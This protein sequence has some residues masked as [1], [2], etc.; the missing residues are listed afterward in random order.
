MGVLPTRLNQTVDTSLHFILKIRNTLPVKHI[1]ISLLK[2]VNTL[3]L[4]DPTFNV[5]GKIDI[6]LGAD[7]LEDICLETRIRDNGVVIRE[8]LFGWVISGPVKKMSNSLD[9]AIGSNVFLVSETTDNLLL[10]FWELENIPIK[11]HL[12]AEEAACENSFLRQLF[13]S[14]M[15][16]SPSN[17]SFV[18]VT[19]NKAS[20]EQAP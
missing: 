15:A 7:V 1:D 17:F 8:S 19:L 10:T 4:A 14:Q 3:P 12:T 5:P 20:A 2:Y 9:Y 6:V 16:G 13:G 18:Q 11:K